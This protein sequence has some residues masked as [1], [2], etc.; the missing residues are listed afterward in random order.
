MRTIKSKTALPGISKAEVY[1]SPARKT[2][3]LNESSV[4]YQKLDPAKYGHVIDCQLS[5]E[6]LAMA[7]DPNVKPFGHISD[8]AAYVRKIRKA[9]RP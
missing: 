6:E 7:N 9:S 4:G 8:S 5:D 1:S 3:E 2:S